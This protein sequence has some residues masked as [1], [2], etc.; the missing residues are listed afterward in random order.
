M[1]YFMV[2]DENVMMSRVDDGSDNIT[3]SPTSD[4]NS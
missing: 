3:L 4:V 2:D 1:F